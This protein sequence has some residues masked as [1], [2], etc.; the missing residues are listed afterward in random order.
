[1]PDNLQSQI[2]ALRRE[3]AEVRATIPT[4]GESPIQVNGNTVSIQDNRITNPQDFGG[5]GSA[6][7]PVTM[8]IIEN[9]VANFYSV[10]ATF[11]GPV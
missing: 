11:I 5:G 3:L 8:I 1:M 7:T 4:K 10:Q 9:G 2:D 6:N